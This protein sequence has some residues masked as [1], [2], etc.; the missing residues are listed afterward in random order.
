MG[1][2]HL[3]QSELIKMVF[4]RLLIFI[5]LL[6]VMFFLPA[7]TFA[8]WEAWLYLTVLI[9]PMV[10]S[11]IYLLKNDPE[12]LERRMRMREKE[13][14]QKLVAKLGALY[15]LIVF[16]IPGF[17]KRYGWSNVP[18]VIV[19]VADVLVLLGYGI[20]FLVLRQN[21]YASRIIEVEPGQEVIS[22]GPYAMVRHPMYLGVSL[23]YIL[24]PLALGSYW[25]M[26][27][28]LLIIPLL[29]VRIRNEE[30]MLGRE[31]KGYKE[32]MQKTKYHLIPG[33]W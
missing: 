14:S 29:V 19:I 3:P 17:D 26:I 7:G 6:L 4:V 21:R 13:A 31:L 20:F 12:L 10:L 33:I 27:P 15:C 2:E 30:T 18:V 9:I 28:A 11:L 16:L 22:G 5:P 23:M 1:N 25:A 24:S 8:Y 32:Y